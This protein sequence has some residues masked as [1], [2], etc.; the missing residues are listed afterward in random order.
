MNTDTGR[1]DDGDRDDRD[2]A[3]T[4][5]SDG[6]TD[7]GRWRDG[8]AAGAVDDRTD[9]GV[10]QGA[11]DPDHGRPGRESGGAYD[12]G[13]PGRSSFGVRWRTTLALIA[14]WIAL[15]GELTIA[16]LLG[17]LAVATVV[18]VVARG[19]K[20]RQPRHLDPVAAVRYLVRFMI[21]L[22][23]S[24]ISVIRAILQPDDIRP[25]IIAM[26]LS[27]A[28]DAVVTLVANSITLTPGTL[29]L[30]IERRGDTAIVY[31]HALDV[32]DEAGLREDIC[33]LEKRAVDAFGGPDAQVIQA[34]NLEEYRAARR[35]YA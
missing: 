20:P 22:V 25:G 3:R 35:D 1:A 28:S 16:N 2:R 7:A 30:D 4:D 9:G 18:L 19:I 34:R 12:P 21:Q 31:V 33:E 11:A 32:S 14:M 8:A 24:N 10:R 6:A 13:G 23:L 15:W 29:T 27:Y 17:G 5:G 26:P